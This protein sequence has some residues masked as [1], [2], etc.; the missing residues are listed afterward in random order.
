MSTITNVATMPNFEIMYDQ[1]N[2]VGISISG[3][4]V[5][6]WIVIWCDYYHSLLGVT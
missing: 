5:Q 6:K 2:S 1:F 4:F 3:D